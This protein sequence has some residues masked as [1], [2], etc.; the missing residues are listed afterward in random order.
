MLHF[1]S[2]S[3][4]GLESQLHAIIFVSAES[5]VCHIFS[6]NFLDR[7]QRRTSA[8]LENCE[9]ECVSRILKST[10]FLT[11]CTRSQ[12]L[13]VYEAT[14][15]MYLHSC[16]ITVSN[17]T[18]FPDKCRAIPIYVI[19]RSAC[20]H[21][22]LKHISVTNRFEGNVRT[23]LAESNKKRRSFANNFGLFHVG[24][25]GETTSFFVRFG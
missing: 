12:Q 20:L 16:L 10:K 2:G 7:M 23:I 8:L 3:S 13:V 24:I 18:L 5:E 6:T 21:E 14:L 19:F 25:D 15:S 17:H 11:F 1:F 9:Y 22:L 4:P